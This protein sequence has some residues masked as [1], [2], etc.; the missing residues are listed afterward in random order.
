MAEFEKSLRELRIVDLGLGM[1]TALVTKFLAESGAKITRVE[2]PEGDPFY[3]L[4]SAYRTWLGGAN[5]DSDAARSTEQLNAHLE[6]ADVCIVGGEDYPGVRWRHDAAALHAHFPS[7]VVLDIEGYPSGTR[8]SGR[9]ASD[10][11]VQA[12]SG[13]SFEHYSQRPFL[14]SFEPSSYGAALHGLAGV[15]GALYQRAATGR[16]QIVATSL[17]EGA[18]SWVLGLWFEGSKP[19]PSARF[20]MPKDPQQLIFRCADGVYVQVVLGSAGSKG[21]LYQV[22]GI[23][24]PRVD[25][26]DSGMPAPTADAR[27]FFGDVDLLASYIEKRRSRELLEAIWAQGLPAEPVLAPGGCWD[28][29]QVIHNGIVLRSVDCVR[30]V[31]HP[32]YA[33]LTSA[34]HRA[35]P[36]IGPRALS[37]VKVVDFGTF[38]AGPYSSVVL[39][40]LGAQVIKVEA[41]TGEPSRSVFRSYSAAARGK[42][43]IAVDLKTPAGRKIA[44][45]LCVAA[46]VVTS[47]FRP[48]VSKRLG[49]DAQTLHAL[50]PDLIVLE[51]AAYGTTG[52][53]ADLAGFD[54]CFQ[55]LCGHGWRAGGVGNPPLWNRTTVVDYAT[56]VLGAIAVLQHLYLRTITGR[57]AAVGS[58]LLN[59]GIYLLSEVIQQPSGEFEG[60]PPL[61]HAQTGYH[62]S[63]RIYEAANGWVAIAAR[64]DATADALLQVLNLGH[65]LKG[66]RATWGDAAAAAISL[67]VRQ[68][69]VRDLLGALES[70]GVWAEECLRNTEHET[71]NDPDLIAAGTVYLSDHP[72]IGNMRQIGPLFR[73]SAARKVPQGHTP[74]PGEH[75]DALLAEIGYSTTEIASLRERRIVA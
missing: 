27:N 60:A 22:L 4:Y 64:S 49:I 11:L 69:R 50:K 56:G 44:E 24:D 12:R 8:H 54:M 35:P 47:N 9:P 32:L 16:G 10:L 59:T 58:S 45:Q 25:I 7:L 37:D 62:P 42:R 48:G 65:F 23:E 46:D 40:D 21:R 38:V 30:H 6:K 75:T 33:R 5:V 18:L 1:A 29:P 71:L 63:Q 26:N 2:P 14:M 15:F 61:N 66:E 68:W 17:F 41:L 43:A 57:G 20:V 3:G 31:G 72:Q 36:A 34:S 51:S 52:P 53:K 28:D 67:A 19:T 55:A 39:A 70:A 13:L 74:L 73:L